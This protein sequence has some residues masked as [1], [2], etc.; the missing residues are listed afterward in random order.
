MKE[1]TSTISD[2]DDQNFN[3]TVKGTLALYVLLISVSFVTVF[4]KLLPFRCILHFIKNPI[5]NCTYTTSPPFTEIMSY[6]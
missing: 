6:Y 4:I 5:N 2:E 3:L 1:K